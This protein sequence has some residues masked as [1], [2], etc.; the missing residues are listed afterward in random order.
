MINRIIMMTDGVKTIGHFFYVKIENFGAHATN[1]VHNIQSLKMENAQSKM[2]LLRNSYTC[3]LRTYVKTLLNGGL[4]FFIYLKIIGR[5]TV[6]A[7]VLVKKKKLTEKRKVKNKVK[8]KKR[9][10]VKNEKK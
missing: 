1:S 6:T 3:L 2:S 5:Q 9:K 10:E 4:L 8:K 7:D